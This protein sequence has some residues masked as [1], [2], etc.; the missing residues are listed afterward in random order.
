MLRL[1]LSGCRSV[2]ATMPWRSLG[3]SLGG[4]AGF[5]PRFAV[6]R[7][8]RIRADGL[9]TLRVFSTTPPP[10]QDKPSRTLRYGRR[11][12]YVALGLGAIYAFDK[13]YNASAISRNLRTVW[14]CALITLDYKFNFTPEKSEKIPELHERV[15]QRMYDLLTSNGGLYI[16]I[17]QAIGANAAVLPKAFQNKFASLFDDAPQLP[18]ST[19][20]N[21]FLK[22]L[23]APPDGPGGIFEIF[24]KEAVASASIAQVHKAKLWGKDEWVAVK[25]QKP[26]VSIQME[27]DLTIYGGVM[28]MFE[29]EFEL[30]VYFAVDFVSDHLRQELDFEREAENASKTA[31]FIESEPTLRG[32]VY[33]PKVYPEYSTKK[34]MVAE[35]IEG[36]R[37]S[38]RKGIRRLVGEKEPIVEDAVPRSVASAPSTDLSS[39]SIAPAPSPISV[40]SPSTSFTF[41]AKPLKGGTQSIMHTMVSL[42]SAQMFNWGWVHCDPHPGNI[43]IRPSPTSPT[44]PQL[45]LIDHGLY[46]QVPEQFKREWVDLWRGM[47]SGDFSQVEN[48]TKSWGMGMPDLL[49]SF[50]LMK[51]VVLRRNRKKVQKE[52]KDEEKKERRPL[53][54][55]EQS[56]LM[57]QKLKGFLT[58]TDRMPKV[59]IFLTRNMRMVQGN[60]QSL[61]SPVNRIKITGYWASKS[62]IRNPN[63]SFGQRIREWW[64]HIVFRG[65]MLSLDISFWKTKFIAWLGDV[66]Y[67]L[68]GGD[69]SSRKKRNFEEELE[70]NMRE[71]AREGLG[72]DVGE[73]VFA[74]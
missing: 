69:D 56:V 17:G 70:R 72:I 22:E 5:R 14:T 18:Y 43:I 11:A 60:N 46:V 28:W 47:L 55:Y 58:D 50:T 10:P 73:G 2:T 4:E 45:V 32:K 7:Y 35:W 74:G 19:I 62:Q 9:R 40:K 48:V 59:L 39:S 27:W 64:S 24:E 49:A 30:P 23:G 53:T 1:G 41:P 57:K 29:R 20:H 37:L 44:Q 66:R 63:L 31:A 15:A 38:D 52:V 16:K 25:V 67:R 61:G 51:P 65:V 26:D 6:E 8:S 68:F 21:V 36:V 12:A 3:Q 33:I 71:F 34:V 42:F 13:Y 54:Q